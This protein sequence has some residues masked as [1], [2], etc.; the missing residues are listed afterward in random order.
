VTARP[1][2]SEEAERED[3]AEYDELRRLEAKIRELRNRRLTLV[4]EVR[5]LSSE[6][7]MLFDARGPRQQVLEAT[8]AEHQ[9]LGRKLS[10]LRHRRDEARNRLNEALARVRDFTFQSPRSEHPH[11]DHLRKEIADLE[12]RQQ[13]HALPLA[14]ENQLI[15]RLRELTKSLGEADKHRAAVEERQRQ[16]KELEGALAAARR[17]VDALG[18]EMAQGRTERERKMQ[19]MREHLVEVGRLVGEI[20]EKSKQRGLVMERLDASGRELGELEREADRLVAR[21]KGRRL[22]AR[23]SIRDYNRSVRETVA[24]P[25]AFARTAEAQLEELLK[26]GK[27]T[28]SG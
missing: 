22:E 20:R 12:M 25:D 21:A 24:G 26:R 3:R 14:E 19:A 27:V 1:P 15:L 16:F 8:H 23:Q 10:E 13:T 28:L 5:R 11:P 7:K 9:G 18:A 17:E 4:S 6:Q 2:L